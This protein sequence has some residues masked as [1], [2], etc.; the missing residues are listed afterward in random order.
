MNHVYSARAGVVT[1]DEF[2]N[3]DGTIA[4][5]PTA[6]DCQVGTAGLHAAHVGALLVCLGGYILRRYSAG[7]RWRHRYSVQY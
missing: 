6:V 7:H 1:A 3:T 2:I 4:L 5:G